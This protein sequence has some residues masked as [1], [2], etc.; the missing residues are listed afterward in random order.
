MERRFRKDS[1]KFENAIHTYATGGVINVYFHII[2][3]GS[4]I[5]NG[6]VPDQKIIDQVAVL[7]SAYLPS[8]FS[9]NLASIDRRTDAS[10]YTMQPGTTAEQE[11]KTALRQGSA[12][13]LNI[14]TCN[15]GGGYLGWATF[16]S[17]YAKAA[18]ND[19]V[20]LLF[21]SLPGGTAVPY[22]LGDTG[23]HEVGHWLGLYHTFQGGC[24]KTGDYVSDTPAEK[25]P[26]FGCP[27]GRDTCRSP[28]VDDVTN[29]MDYTDDACMNHLTA[30]QV[31]RA[32]KQYTLYRLGK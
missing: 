7:N 15:P 24:S 13:D 20:C 17:S 6:D 9:F 1:K 3:N 29:F 25:S 21:S 14:Y 5:D 11:A 32:N 31:D 10:W 18:K 22:N 16:P 12:D 26:A 30:G 27:L 23:T 4:G 2:N 19:G 8:G 28:G